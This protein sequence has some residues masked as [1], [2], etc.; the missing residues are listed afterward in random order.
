MKAG[1]IS[2]NFKWFNKI[3]I[4][5]TA[6]ELKCFRLRHLARFTIPDPKELLSNSFAAAATIKLKRSSMNLVTSAKVTRSFR[7]NSD[8][9][10]SEVKPTFNLY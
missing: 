3:F 7:F 6:L 10:S 8:I 1:I 4:D 9:V 2:K 5:S